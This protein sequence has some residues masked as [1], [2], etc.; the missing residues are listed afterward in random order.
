MDSDEI[1]KAFRFFTE[2][3][4]IAQLSAR[5]LEKHLPERLTEIHFGLLSHLSRR[6]AGDTPQQLAFAFQVP[7]TSMTHMVKVLQSEVAIEVV[8]NPDDE[9]SKIAKITPKGEALIKAAIEGM[10]AE[11]AQMQPAF[12]S[13]HVAASLTHL[14]AIRSQLD[15]ARNKERPT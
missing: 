13:D 5:L 15:T 7:K 14:E 8:P 12:E 1:A 6:P 3:G 2:V 9:R 4:I 10:S 11:V